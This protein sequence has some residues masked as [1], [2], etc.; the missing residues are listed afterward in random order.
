MAGPA[1]A[2]PKAKER[3][4]R[5]MKKLVSILMTAVMG[6]GM[7]MTAPLATDIVGKASAQQRFEG[8][9]RVQVDQD[10]FVRRGDR[11]FRQQRRFFPRIIIIVDRERPWNRIILSNRF[12]GF[13]SR[14]VNIVTIRVSHFQFVR[15]LRA[16]RI[17]ND[18]NV[19]IN[20]GRNIVRFNTVVGDISTGDVNVSI[21]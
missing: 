6:I 13:G 19:N 4:V 8:R 2:G 16:Y 18:I 15:L 5:K 3:Q 10:Y 14:N 20:T 9:G 11:R 1:V 17:D 12:T 21:R 7:F